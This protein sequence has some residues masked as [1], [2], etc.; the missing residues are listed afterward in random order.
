MKKVLFISNSYG[1]D[2]TRYLYGV[3][4]AA[5]EKLKVMTLYIGGCSLARHYRNML[6]GDPAYACFVNGMSTGIYVSLKQALLSDEWDVVVMQ[7]CSPQSG[8][9]ESYEPYLSELSAYVRKMVPKAQQYMQMTWTFAEGAPRFKLTRFETRA[10]MIPA[11]VEAYTEA[12]ASIGADALVPAMHAMCKLYD[13]IGDKAYRDGYH[14]SFGVARY[15]LACLWFIA[16]YRRDFK[17][18]GYTDFDVAVTEDEVAL[19]ERIA[20][21]VARD[22]GFLV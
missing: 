18:N 17:D 19:A 22:A 1:E 10:E 2:A 4:R 12:A 21:E 3:A 15:M 16:L 7:Q 8:H 14:C 9:P 5:G 11:V 6:S 20:R 13:A